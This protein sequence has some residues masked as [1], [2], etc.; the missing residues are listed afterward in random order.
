MI[1]EYLLDRDRLGV[2]AKSR[3][4][5]CV[6]SPVRSA[7]HRWRFEGKLLWK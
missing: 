7:I 1:V 4:G 3:R 6:P 2:T 5:E